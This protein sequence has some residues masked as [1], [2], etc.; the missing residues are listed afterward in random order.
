MCVE[1]KKKEIRGGR[2]GGRQSS[3]KTNFI[4]WLLTFDSKVKCISRVSVE[5]IFKKL[6][7]E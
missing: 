4:E 2:G 1:S 5:L 7:K 3:S 6:T